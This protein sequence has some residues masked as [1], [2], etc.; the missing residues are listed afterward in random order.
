M[1]RGEVPGDLAELLARLAKGLSGLYGERYAGLVLYGSYARGEPDAGNDVDVL[2]LLRGD[3]EPA[4][5]I[6]RAEDMKWS[7]AL[8]YGYTVALLRLNIVE[9]RS[10]QEPLVW[11]V[12][13]EGIPAA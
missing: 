3:V 9:Y 13:R 2:L 1:Q 11:N 7:L 12:R 6:L 8:E 4:R 5:Q 10:S